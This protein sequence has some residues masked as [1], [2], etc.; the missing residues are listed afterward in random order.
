M[1]NYM[2]T[3]HDL[4]Q[5]I[6]DEDFVAAKE[7]TNSLVFAAVSS[8]LEAAKMEVAS[9]LFDV[10]EGS[11]CDEAKMSTV[12]SN[13]NGRLQ[14]IHHEVVGARVNAGIRAGNIPPKKAAK[15]KSFG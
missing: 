4:L 2:P 1:E 9:K 13:M 10:C 5:A 12:D 3:P 6:V 14:P 11:N 8:Q 15:M 7:I